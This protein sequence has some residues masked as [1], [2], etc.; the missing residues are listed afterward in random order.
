MNLYSRLF[1][2]GKLRYFWV[3]TLS[4]CHCT[5]NRYRRVLAVCIAYAS[6]CQSHNTTM[7]FQFPAG[8]DK[9][10]PDQEVALS[11]SSYGDE[12]FD[13]KPGPG[14]FFPGDYSP[15]EM[16]ELF[17]PLLTVQERVF[18]TTFP[19]TKSFPEPEKL[20][21]LPAVR[22]LA[23]GWRERTHYHAGNPDFT[24]QDEMAANTQSEIIITEL[25]VTQGKSH[26]AE[27]TNEAEPESTGENAEATRSAYTPLSI[28]TNQASEDDRP[29]EDAQVHNCDGSNCAACN[30]EPCHC[31]EC[32]GRTQSL[33]VDAPSGQPEAAGLAT[34]PPGSAFE[35]NSIVSLLAIRR[36]TGQGM[37]QQ[38]LR[39]FSQYRLEQTEA[40]ERS[41][42]VEDMNVV[43]AL[44]DGT[45]IVQGRD[46]DELAPP[47]ILAL[48]QL[49]HWTTIEISFPEDSVPIEVMVIDS[50]QFIVQTGPFY[51]YF[52]KQDR[53]WRSMKLGEFLSLTLLNDGRF[54]ATPVLN[55][56]TNQLHGNYQ[57]CSVNHGQ[58]VMIPIGSACG[59]LFVLEKTNR[60]MTFHDNDIVK[61]WT[62]INGLWIASALPPEPGLNPKCIVELEDGQIISFSGS[63][64]IWNQ[65]S[66]RWFYYELQKELPTPVD[67]VVLE[68][69][70]FIIF[71]DEYQHDHTPSSSLQLWSEHEGKWDFTNLDH[72]HRQWLIGALSISKKEF[73]TWSYDSVKAWTCR[74]TCS[75]VEL[76]GANEICEFQLLSDGRLV[77]TT[78]TNEVLIWHQHNSVWSYRSFGEIPGTRTYLRKLFALPQGYLAATYADLFGLLRMIP[79]CDTWFWDLFPQTREQKDKSGVE[80]LERVEDNTA[81]K[82]I[83]PR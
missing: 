35:G 46:T 66:G 83:P 42:C 64:G 1:F 53:C 63:L 82:Y 78:E 60:I 45:L 17:R 49:K 76:A 67:L 56:A 50:D 48:Q 79:Y 47:H 54:V 58:L 14:R 69:S 27:K 26:K 29:P 40:V 24:Q 18:Q 72:R 57:V 32:Q 38:E 11:G 81:I 12:P 39:G 15:I 65:V 73:I 75:Y 21:W 51:T 70:R 16:V 6:L 77:S 43:A 41:L 74:E 9:S 68:R 10:A 8:P 61:V 13:Q 28:N 23:I 2:L 30:F 59:Y 20:A 52:S 71:W 34:E 7:F 33:T 62:E 36:R 5:I 25:P 31:I 19:L 4:Q 3:I 37:T 44:P 22:R 55:P 80:R